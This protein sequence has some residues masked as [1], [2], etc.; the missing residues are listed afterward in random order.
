MTEELKTSS[1]HFYKPGR[2]AIEMEVSAEKPTALTVAELQDAFNKVTMIPHPFKQIGFNEKTLLIQPD[3]KKVIP[4]GGGKKGFPA[5]LYA[6]LESNSD[7]T[8]DRV[9]KFMLDVQQQ[10][11]ED[12]DWSMIFPKDTQLTRV[13]YDWGIGGTSDATHVPP[14]SPGTYPIPAEAHLYQGAKEHPTPDEKVRVYVVDTI[15]SKENVTQLE[16]AEHLECH[17]LSEL[18]ADLEKSGQISSINREQLLR[19]FEEAV[20]IDDPD[21]PIRVNRDNHGLFI[22]DLIHCIAPKAKIVMVQV[23]NQYCYGHVSTYAAVMQ[24]LRKDIDTYLQDQDMQILVNCSF[25]CLAPL[26]DHNIT[27]MLQEI[28]EDEKLTSEEKDRLKKAYAAH[29]DRFEKLEQA[30][31]LDEYINSQEEMLEM[32]SDLSVNGKRRMAFIAAVGNDSLTNAPDKEERRKEARYPARAK[33]VWGVGGA[34]SK[35]NKHNYVDYSNQRDR[36]PRDG[37]KAWGGTRKPHDFVNE[38]MTIYIPDEGIVGVYPNGTFPYYGDKEPTGYA[39]WSGTS[40]AT[41]RVTGLIAEAL[42]G[43][44][45]LDNVRGKIELP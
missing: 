17:Y 18:L 30:G 25:A 21:H 40:F 27:A 19:D 9:D 12:K 3:S 11:K 44:A 31:F 7:D 41:G 38:K 6:E 16:W 45:T 14:G 23:M 37:F 43:G 20:P 35:A 34:K 15:P 39:E 1:F 32:F 24:W 2:I 8:A 26:G 10:L 4:Q 42:L 36:P 29:A 22:A 28:F 5:V 33:D 13:M